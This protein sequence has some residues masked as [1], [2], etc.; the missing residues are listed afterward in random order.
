[1]E[2]LTT[3]YPI[4]TFHPKT[5]KTTPKNSPNFNQPKENEFYP[6]QMVLLSY[7]R[8]VRYKCYTCVSDFCVFS[9]R[10]S[11]LYFL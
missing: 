1:M 7:L 3:I 8:F 10:S 4:K 6:F 9:T 11:Y 5:V 2:N